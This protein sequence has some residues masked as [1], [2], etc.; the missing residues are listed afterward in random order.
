MR[1]PLIVC[2]FFAALCGHSQLRQPYSGPFRLGNYQGNAN[3]TY[4]IIETDTVLDGTFQIKRSNLEAL[5]Q[6]SDSSFFIKGNFTNNY[7]NGDWRFQFGEFKSDSTTQ[8][9]D[10]QYKLNV[11]GTQNEAYGTLD[12]GKPTGKW[13]FIT[14]EIENSEIAEISFKSVITFDKGIPQK[15][16]QIQNINSTLVG[17]FL[18]NGLAHDQWTLYADED[19]EATE[20]WQFS[21]G[22][23][24]KI[25][26]QEDG[27]K[28]VIPIYRSY[29]KNAK[30]ITMDSRYLEILKL[31]VSRVED[32][33]ALEQ[34][35][36]LLL[37]ENA[38]HYEKI[39]SLLSE[40]SEADFYPKFK[41]RVGHY[42]FDTV[43]LAQIDTIKTRHKIA[44]QITERFLQNTQLN[45]LRLSDTRAAY[46]FKVIETFS[47]NYVAPIE[48]LLNYHDSGV[49]NLLSRDELVFSLWNEGIPAK[50]LSFEN[51]ETYIGPNADQYTFDENDMASI[52]QLFAYTFNSLKTIENEL[53]AKLVNDKRKQ[54]YI[55]IEEQLI[56]KRDEL[57]QKI[58]S[59]PT[60]FPK[61]YSS[62]LKSIHEHADTQLAT[63]SNMQESKSKLE[64][65]RKL[66]R[67][68]GNLDALAD[69][70][71]LQP[72][73]IAEIEEKYLD[74]I[75][76]PFMATIMNEEVKKRITT[77]YRKVLLPHLLNIT[78]NELSCENAL[79]LQTAYEEI[80][81]KMLQLRDE[82]TQKL[83]RKLKRA[84]EPKTVM[85]LFNMQP[86][87]EK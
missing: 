11:N 39:N 79:S 56:G 80:H 75:W 24:R 52:E 36:N 48:K 38:K 31:K 61:K 22:W 57:N 20:N 30:T 5:L 49:A 1:F 82:E 76:N 25:E 50:E 3:Y 45:I 81:E 29:P 21:D 55:T 2:I 87:S 53:N 43:E 73:R 69:A 59:V 60:T 85:Q 63:Y 40:V 13:N 83:E 54:E 47:K 77:A 6:K 33:D 46:L 51:D 27:R 37:Q 16:F 74:A 12:M 35:M 78:T 15:S 32:F 44:K 62:A 14:N 86:L 68:F 58:D 34:S 67:C 65:G 42:P 84:Q 23:L 71:I 26:F 41:V 19:L 8:V 10:Y 7:P 66:V 18:R 72:E 70:V 9:V 4:K 64:L 28:R 17:R